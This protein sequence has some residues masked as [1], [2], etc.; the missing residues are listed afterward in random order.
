[1]LASQHAFQNQL[2]IE[3]IVSL[4]LLAGCAGVVYRIERRRF[5]RRNVAGLQ[6]FDSFGGGVWTLGWEGLLSWIARAAG[7]FSLLFAITL[8]IFIHIGNNLPAPQLADAEWRECAAK[9][10]PSMSAAKCGRK[11]AP[12]SARV[13]PSS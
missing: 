9:V 2:V 1:M 11:S 8:G 3:M 12:T 10:G 6:R 7:V 4:V 13:T 5:Y